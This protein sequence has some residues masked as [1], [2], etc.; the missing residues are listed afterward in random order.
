MLAS[1]VGLQVYVCLGMKTL[2]N[3]PSIG[4]GILTVYYCLLHKNDPNL[5]YNDIYHGAKISSLG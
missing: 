3:A 5:G 4:P 2:F 1:R